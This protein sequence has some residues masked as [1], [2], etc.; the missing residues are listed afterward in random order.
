MGFT[1]LPPEIK[2]EIAFHL[3]SY[4]DLISLA[5]VNHQLGK[6]FGTQAKEC[7]RINSQRCAGLTPLVE[8]SILG[9]KR[10][11]ST[12]LQKWAVVDL[13]DALGRTPLSWASGSGHKDVVHKLLQSGARA[14]KSDGF[15]RTALSWAAEKG[16]FEVVKLLV[17]GGA[18]FPIE[19]PP[20]I[21]KLDNASRKLHPNLFG[22]RGIFSRRFTRKS[23]RE[24]YVIHT[25]LKHELCRINPLSLAEKNGHEETVDFLRSTF[26]H[27]SIT[28]VPG[29]LSLEQNYG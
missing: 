13:P 5:Q 16:H 21:K 25:F 23:V 14:N 9:D 28:T 29:L 19:R 18:E 24:R 12:L 8:A 22:L 3:S 6:L 26:A 27:Y 20:N 17:H 15:G 4:K 1:H 7:V 10:R 11:V 2:W